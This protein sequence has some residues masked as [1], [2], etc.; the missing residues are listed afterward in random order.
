[1]IQVSVCGYLRGGGLYNYRAKG[2]A[3]VTDQQYEHLTQGR[4]LAT[5]NWL[6]LL[7]ERSPFNV[8]Y[9]GMNFNKVLDLRDAIVR[10]L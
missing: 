10:E 8:V 2:S 9:G 6:F 5:G 4:A 1:M 3:V 7:P